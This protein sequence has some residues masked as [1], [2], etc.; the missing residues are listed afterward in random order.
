MT[1]TRIYSFWLPE[2][3]IEK[4]GSYLKIRKVEYFHLPSEFQKTIEKIVSKNKTDFRFYKAGW[5]IDYL[6]GEQAW[7]G[8]IDLPEELLTSDS[9]GNS[10][11]YCAGDYDEEIIASLKKTLSQESDGEVA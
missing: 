10:Y 2:V 1:E 11:S 3:V 7:L 5:D 9:L 8:H 4:Q 6:T